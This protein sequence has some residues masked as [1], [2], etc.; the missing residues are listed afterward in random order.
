MGIF[1]KPTM[2]KAPDPPPP[3]PTPVDEAVR[4]RRAR[5]KAMGRSGRSDTALTGPA[6]LVNR[7]TISAPALL[8][9]GGSPVTRAPGGG[10]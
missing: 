4:N 1:S 2:P 3:P 5:A 8:G 10:F 6:G 7:G 9:G